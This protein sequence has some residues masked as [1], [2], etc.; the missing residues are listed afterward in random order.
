MVLRNIIKTL[1]KTK[2]ILI[3]KEKIR[4]HHP[5]NPTTSSYTCATLCPKERRHVFTSATGHKNVTSLHS[6]P[7]P[8]SRPTQEKSLDPVLLKLSQTFKSQ[9]GHSNIHCS[10]RIPTIYPLI[11]HTHLQPSRA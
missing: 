10:L 5:L 1:I 2:K 9:P 3:Q 4:H 11:H 8:G 7:L 6:P